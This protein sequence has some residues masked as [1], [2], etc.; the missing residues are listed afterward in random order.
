VGALARAIPREAL[1][2]I[3]DSD[4]DLHAQVALE[5]RGGRDVLLLPLA[6][7]SEASVEKPMAGFLARRLAEGRRVCLLLAKPDDLAGSLVRH[8]RIDFL[9]E[10]T[11]PF[12]RVDLVPPDAFPPPPETALLRTVVA[13]LRPAGE[14]PAPGSILVGDQR[15]DVGFLVQGFH[16]P[17]VEARPGQPPRPFRW[18]GPVATMAFPPVAA[19]TLILDTSRPPRAAPARMEASLDGVPVPVSTGAAGAHRV[20]VPFGETEG[21]AAKRIVGLRTNAFRMRDL[22][23]SADGRELGV[24]VMSVEIEP[25]GEVGPPSPLRSPASAP[26]PPRS[27][28]SGPD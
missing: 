4:A 27:A 17:E 18:T 23:L 26:P 12:A 7:G 25:R 24:R 10:R 28:A 5:Y 9:F 15:Q 13:E 20:R 22:G 16:A 11:V 19:I 2:V 8:F 14:G 6:D 1:I 3:P 21:S